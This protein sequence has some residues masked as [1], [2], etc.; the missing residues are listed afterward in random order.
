MAAP[1]PKDA[2]CPSGGEVAGFPPISRTKTLYYRPYTG[3][4]ICD[5]PFYWDVD[6]RKI[7]RRTSD[8]SWST[9]APSP[10]PQFIGVCIHGRH[11]ICCGVRGGMFARRF[12][13][14][15]PDA[16]IYGVSHLGGD[17]FSANVIV[18]PSGYLL[19]RLDDADDNELRELAENGLLPLANLRGRLGLTPVEA[20]AE[21]WYRRQFQQRNPLHIPRITVVGSPA[22]KPRRYRVRVVHGV[23]YWLLEANL[24]PDREISIRYT[25]VT[26]EKRLMYRW[27]VRLVGEGGNA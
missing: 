18:L 13:G 2:L 19:G 27:N 8:G 22:Q 17:R 6:V 15:L 20:V 25:C 11:D 4:S 23:R 14:L 3:R 24:E 21:I 5:E 9:I 12:R 7:V 10:V 16:P 1:W 26:R